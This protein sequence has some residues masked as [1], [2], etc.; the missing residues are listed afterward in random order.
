MKMEDIPGWFFLRGAG[1]NLERRERVLGQLKDDHYPVED[2]R[3][4]CTRFF[5]DIHTNE[6]SSPASSYGHSRTRQALITTPVP[7][8]PA[9]PPQPQH[10]GAEK[11]PEAPEDEWQE[12]EEAAEVNV[13]DLR[14]ILQDELNGFASDLGA[15]GD[16]VEEYLDPTVAADLE[17]ACAQVSDASEALQMIRD[18]R[19]GL[20]G[21]GKGK[22]K[23]KGKSEGKSGGRSSS[24]PQAAIRA[25][26]AKGKCHVCGKM[27]HWSGDPVCP[28][29][30]ASTQPA[31]APPSRGVN[32]TELDTDSV[33]IHD[34]FMTEP[35]VAD[36]GLEAPVR[37]ARRAVADSACRFSVAGSHW[38]ADYRK[39]LEDAGLLEFLT[40][41]AEHERYRFGNN[42]TL[43]NYTRVKSPAVIAGK[44]YLIEFSV[45]EIDRLA[46]LLGRDI[47]ESLGA[48]MD[49]SPKSPALRI[50]SGNSPLVNSDAGHYAIDLKPESWRAIY[51]AHASFASG[52]TLLRRLRTR[53]RS[54]PATSATLATSRCTTSTPELAP[55]KSRR[56]LRLLAALLKS[57]LV[58]AAMCANSIL[59]SDRGGTSHDMFTT[60]IP[61]A[62]RCDS[63]YS[64]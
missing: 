35:D 1:L 12:E 47:L 31:K 20:K 55:S 39:A 59:E 33:P 30:S 18:V 25:K 10:Q 42:G 62:S 53:S 57:V 36:A 52:T 21:R 63:Y 48:M 13:S 9:E 45:V 58:C 28:G 8:A 60:S 26:K 44:A 40:E 64:Q 5:P 38:Y 17:R 56:L 49:M 27:G 50:G 16:G 51:D 41:T 32:Q 43:D 34:V 46:L 23:S 61:C 14:N 6:R 11:H 2:I 22:G 4:I 37:D 54:G 24:D 3:N 29:P 19:A 7:M 15:S